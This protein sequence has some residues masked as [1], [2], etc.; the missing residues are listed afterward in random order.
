MTSERKCRLLPGRVWGKR[1]PG[2]VQR[3]GPKRPSN[4]L[5]EH[6]QRFLEKPLDVWKDAQPGHERRA[7]GTLKASAAPAISPAEDKQRWW[8]RRAKAPLPHRRCNCRRWALPGR[9]SAVKPTLN[10]PLPPDQKFQFWEGPSSASAHK[11]NDRHARL[12]TEAFLVG[13]RDWGEKQLKSPWTG[14]ASVT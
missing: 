6:E 13:E 8:L 3:Q 7:N 5:R 2:G 10:V 4:N 12:L 14:P 9:Y 1:R 11:Q